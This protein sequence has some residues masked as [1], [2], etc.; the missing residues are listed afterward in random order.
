MKLRRK[1]KDIYSVEYGDFPIGFSPCVLILV[2][3]LVLRSEDREDDVVD[4]RCHL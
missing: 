3:S 1:K 4:F 2:L